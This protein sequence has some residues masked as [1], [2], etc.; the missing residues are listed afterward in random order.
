MAEQS[1]ARA[2]GK[3]LA[4]KKKTAKKTEDQPGLI[5]RLRRRVRRV[6]MWSVLGVTAFVLLGTL[7]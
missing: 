1:K 3:K 7:L 6:L 4:P 5:T 2:K